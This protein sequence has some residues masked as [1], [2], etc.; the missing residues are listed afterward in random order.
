MANVQQKSETIT[1][2]S[3]FFFFWDNFLVISQCCA[4]ENGL[5]GRSAAKYAAKVHPHSTN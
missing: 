3:E 2:F 4:V 5:K 1:A